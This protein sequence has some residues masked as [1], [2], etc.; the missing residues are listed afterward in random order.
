MD[1]GDACL[2]G[3]N[4][5][6]QEQLNSFLKH[7]TSNFLHLIDSHEGFWLPR[8]PEFAEAIRFKLIQLGDLT[9]GSS[10]EPGGFNVFGFIDCVG[11]STCRPGSGPLW[12]GSGAPRKDPLI[13]RSMYNGWKKNHGVKYQTVDLPCG[14]H[15]N[16]WGPESI[17]WNDIDTW[18]HSKAT[19]KIRDCQ[20]GMALKF[21]VY[22]DGAYQYLVDNTLASRYRCQS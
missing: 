15:W 6:A 10:Y 12:D 11:I 2:A 8:L 13:Q 3:I 9:H 17:K 20:A 5:G 7:M 21:K 22:G 4:L 16:V 14:L 19:E 1:L 18:E